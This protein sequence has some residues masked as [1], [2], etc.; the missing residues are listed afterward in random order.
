MTVY[1]AVMFGI[2]LLG[3]ASLIFQTSENERALSN[4]PV[5]IKNTDSKFD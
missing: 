2:L 5:P 1:H 4:N 3:L